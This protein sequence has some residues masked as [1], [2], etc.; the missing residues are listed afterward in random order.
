MI[1]TVHTF[2]GGV[3]G[4]VLQ[5]P[6]LALLLGIFLHFVLDA[7][8][9]YDNTDNSR[10]TRR[11]I[12]FTAVDFIIAGLLLYF[13]LEI[14]VS[15]AAFGSAVFWGAFGGFLPDL[16]DNVPFWNKQ[17]HSTKIGKKFHKFHDGIHQKQPHFLLGLS[18]QAAIV[19]LFYALHFMIK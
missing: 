9:H 15:P 18:I 12:I 7:I 10:W 13:V 6:F 2:A 5:N 11:Q 17:W 4:E 14:P 19:L 16:I 1:V 8:P 3:A